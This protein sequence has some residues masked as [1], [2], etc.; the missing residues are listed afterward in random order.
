[1]HPQS[2]NNLFTFFMCFGVMLTLSSKPIAS[3]PFNKIEVGFGVEN[4]ML[5]NTIYKDLWGTSN[6]YSISVRTPYYFGNLELELEQFE[7]QQL[8]GAAIFET[9]NMMIGVSISPLNHQFVN[10][11]LG[12][13]VGIQKISIEEE[14]TVDPIN[15]V[16]REL[17]LSYKIQPGITFQNF[18]FYS[19]FEYRRTYYY[20][21]QNM[22]I[23]GFGIR[24]SFLLPDNLRDLID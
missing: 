6:S 24:Y 22:F 12:A 13:F 23:T 18:S 16:E 2:T 19:N 4:P 7:Y 21:I 3:Q 1:M 15:L 5:L 9:L 20:E 14:L 17:L 8:E 10:L 11:D